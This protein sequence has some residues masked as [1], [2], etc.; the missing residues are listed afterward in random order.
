MQQ[1]KNQ[2][3]GR[4]IKKKKDLL[5]K[6]KKKTKH[7]WATKDQKQSSYFRGAHLAKT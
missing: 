5:Q 1:Q 2:Q 6:K 4:L 7:K 3:R